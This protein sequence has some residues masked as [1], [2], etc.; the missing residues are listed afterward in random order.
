MLSSMDK[1]PV[2]II[3]QILCDFLVDLLSAPGRLYFA[4]QPVLQL[5]LVSKATLYHLQDAADL[6]VRD[7][8][9]AMPRTQR[10]FTILFSVDDVRYSRAALNEVDSPCISR[11]S[12]LQTVQR[13]AVAQEMVER[14][15]EG[16]VFRDSVKRQRSE[17]EERVGNGDLGP[18]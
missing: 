7:M 6:I 5:M 16:V 2:D 11:R 13:L 18:V 17:S 1:L 14:A 8:L 12:A 9:R 4:L 3:T 10:R 15:V